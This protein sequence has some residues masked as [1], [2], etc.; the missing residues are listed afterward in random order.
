MLGPTLPARPHRPLIGTIP[1]RVHGTFAKFLRCLT[2]NRARRRSRTQN[3]QP[4]HPWFRPRSRVRPGGAD[5]VA[6]DPNLPRPRHL[7]EPAPARRPGRRLGERRV[8]YHP[9]DTPAPPPVAIKITQN[10]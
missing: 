10:P 7:H 5:L 8:T 9:Q 4:V 6:P 2:A 3:D 1:I